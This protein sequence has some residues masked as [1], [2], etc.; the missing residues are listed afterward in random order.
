VKQNS[1]GGQIHSGESTVAPTLNFY[2]RLR[3]LNGRPGPKVALQHRAG[4]RYVRLF[5]NWRKYEV[6]E[7]AV[8]E[9]RDDLGAV[10]AGAVNTSLAEPTVPLTALGERRE[11]FERVFLKFRDA[12]EI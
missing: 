4:N 1:Y 3:P 10:F 9:Y 6:S 2:I 5:L 8:D 11:E 7:R 12:I